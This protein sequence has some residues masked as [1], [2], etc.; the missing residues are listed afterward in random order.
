MKVD[1]VIV[2]WNSGDQLEACI[3]SVR[4]YGEGWVGR[5]TVIDNGSSDA[6]LDFLADATDVDLVRAGANLG[7]GVACNR[8]AK[9]G[10]SPYVLFLNPDAALFPGSLTYAISHLENPMNQTIGIL[11]VQLVDE[12]GSV[13]RTCARVPKPS[14]WL[15]KSFGLI[16]LLPKLD[17][18][19]K[20]WDH[21]DSRIVDHVMG[22]FFFVR[23]NL[24]NRL[25]GFD[26]R[27]FV[28]LEDLD[29]SVRAKQIGF[30]SY[31]LSGASAYHKGGGVSEQVKAHR[32]FYSLRSRIQYAAKHF[33]P[34]SAFAVRAATL[35]IEPLTR[36]AF[37]VLRG[38]AR[39]IK[40][41]FRGYGMLW[42]W[43]LQLRP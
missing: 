37:L 5:C 10:D 36:L 17:L 12:S 6:S 38:R 43:A 4:K 28:Y 41:L 18:H 30:S 27:F 33:D 19:C 34:V 39:E 29:F 26:E 42:Q 31:Y 22:A 35:G 15:V 1:I 20:D 32:L 8:G 13:Q 25:K 16:T 24:F 9:R 21:G 40:D 11:G 3:E 23:R 7:F 2:N 14:N